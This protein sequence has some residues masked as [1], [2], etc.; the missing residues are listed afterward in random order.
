M[1]IFLLLVFALLLIYKLYLDIKSFS[2]FNLSLYLFLAF[3]FILFEI[4]SRG[5]D[6]ILYL[7]LLLLFN[8]LATNYGSKKGIVFS[9]LLLVALPFSK[10]GILLAQSGFLGI[11]PSM[12]KL[13]EN[14]E[15]KKENKRLEISRD[16]VHLIIGIAI[17]SFTALLPDPRQLIV[18]LITMGFILGSYTIISKGKFSRMLY[19]FERK[20]T[21]FGSGAIWLAL[22]ALLA[23]GFIFSR[24]FLIAVLAAIFIGDPLA[25]IVGVKFGKHRIFYNREKSVEGSSAYFAA[26]LAVSYPFIGLYAL[27]V[28]LIAAFVESWGIKIDDNLMVPIILSILLFL[29]YI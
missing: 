14:S 3:G 9:I 20:N 27:P 11:M 18:A 4:E 10:S 8:L 16:V 7:S 5:I 21:Y 23:M 24:N 19:K 22:G 12:L 26:V 17:I 25:T 15:N 28:A 29:F 1:T 6:A 13:I 2:K